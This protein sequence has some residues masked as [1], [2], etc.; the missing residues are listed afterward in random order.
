MERVG[1]FNS[2]GLSNCGRLYGCRLLNSSGLLSGLYDRCG[3]GNIL[4]R[5]VQNLLMPIIVAVILRTEVDIIGAVCGDLIL[6]I[7]AV[8]EPCGRGLAVSG[9][10]DLDAVVGFQIRGNGVFLSLCAVNSGQLQAAVYLP[11][12]EVTDEVVACLCRIDGGLNDRG[13]FLSRLYDCGCF[14]SGYNRSNKIDLV[15]VAFLLV[16]GVPLSAV[17]DILGDID[18]LAAVAVEDDA[19]HVSRNLCGVDLLAVL[20]DLC[21]IHRLAR[22]LG[23]V[24]PIIDMYV[25]PMERVGEFNSDGLSNCGRLYGCR[26]LNSSGLLSG[27]YDRCG[28]GN[29]LCRRVQNL[30]MPIIVAVILRTEV[31][32]IGA[33][34]GDLILVIHAVREPCGRG[35]A[36][37]GVYDLDAV[38]GFQIRGNGVFL[39]LCAVNSGQLQAAVY[40]PLGEVTDEVVACLC[41]ID[42]GLNDRGRFLS[43]LYDCGCF[44]SGYNRSNK[45]DLVVVAFL[46]VNGVP[47]SAVR[48]IL[49]DIDGLAAVAVEDDALHV[50]RNLCGV[51]LLAV[52]VDL[53]LIHRLARPLGA[54][55]PIIDMYVAP[56]ERVGEFNSDGLSNCG[57]LYGCRLLNSS[58]LLSGLY[59]RCGLGNILCRRVQNLLMPIIVAVILRTEVDI[60]GAVCGDLI[61]VIHAVREPCGRGLAVSG[62]YDLDAVVGFQIR[63][64][65]VFLSL[66]AV[67]SGQLQAAVYLP[68]GE[69]TDEVVACLCRIDGGL[70]DRGR[71]LSRLYDCGCFLSGYNRSN[72]IDLVVVAFLLVNGVPLSAVRD[73]LGDI[74]GLAAVAV[75]DDALHVSRN[76]C[77]V[78]LLAVLVDLCLIHRLARPLGAVVPIID[79]DVAPIKRVGE[80]NSD[81]LCGFC[82]R[83]FCYRSFR[84]GS[85][86]RRSGC[87]L[88]GSVGHIQRF[89]SVVIEDIRRLTGC[90]VL[91]EPSV[92]VVNLE[93]GRLRGDGRG[94]HQECLR[95]VV[96]ERLAHTAGLGGFTVTFQLRVIR[97]DGAA[98]I[99]NLPV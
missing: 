28:L 92:A 22:P 42:G 75:E 95:R 83:R 9:V 45:I 88:G 8:R 17:R 30:L 57:R 79:M 74:D 49:G 87:R 12:G 24:V 80:F 16:N 7:H 91:A 27:L 86:S 14:L 70:N 69:V 85:N 67:N 99:M 94:K 26:L 93:A 53:C 90:A 41:R 6:V 58:G 25:A 13:R 59:D 31:D 47:L 61:L 72:K 38:V 39:S 52:L 65:G 60:I 73:I 35:L 23:A 77:G 34:C 10:Y 5:R 51:D 54:V 18:G 76:L 4:C 50:S 56:M 89:V 11:L 29:I 32:I 19:L 21:L 66:C 15:V 43:R 37:S 48:D 44:L 71:F 46:L 98:P 33:V 68:L 55:V 20:V 82:R 36:V 78:D 63:G 64:N 1:E 97:V 96:P 81:G 62:V 2:D 40:L 3:L 84:H